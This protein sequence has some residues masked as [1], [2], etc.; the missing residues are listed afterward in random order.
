[1]TDKQSQFARIDNAL[2]TMDAHFSTSKQPNKNATMNNAITPFQ[3]ENN[4]IRVVTGDDGEPLF[5]GKDICE[6]LGYKDPTTA[7]RNHCK[8]V[9]KQHPLKTA[10]GMQELRVLTESDVMRLVV[11]STLP[12]A[13]AFE[14]LVFDEIL[15][16]IRK[17]GSYSTNNK[18][19]PTPSLVQPA[20]EFRA[21]YGIARLIGCDKNA[22]AIS[23]NQAVAT[24]T[25]TNMLQLLGHTHIEAQDQGAQ[26]FT[27]TEL[28][29]IIGAPARGVNLLLA[30]AGMQLKRGE[31]WE[32]T[33]AG[34]AFARLYDT[35]KKHGSGVPITQIKWS[36]AVL[37][38]LGEAKEAA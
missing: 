25:G 6:A 14:R 22:A 24:F 29:K 32:V 21:M 5:V 35:G 31:V 16:T 4:A 2:D 9:Q 15:P 3:F 12:A 26:Y 36:T 19:A 23:A 11:N 27:P 13:E 10:G 33:D 1:M 7:I 20:K 34:R 38:L 8:G 18:T 17:T 30:E 37:P 28:G